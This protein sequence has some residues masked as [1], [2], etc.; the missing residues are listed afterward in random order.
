MF[1]Q[2]GDTNK[3]V[4]KPMLIHFTRN[5]TTY[6]PQGFHI[7]VLKA[8]PSFLYE[9]NKAVPWRYVVQVS[10]GRQGVSLVH[11]EYNTSTPKVT[12]ISGISGIAHSERVFTP[13]KL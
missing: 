4:P 9:S 8:L 3:N 6:M 7:V 5:A 11:D 12:N 2:S 1:M 10:E 13:P